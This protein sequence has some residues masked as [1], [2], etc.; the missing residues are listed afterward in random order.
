MISER[1]LLP[2]DY[3]LGPQASE[4]CQANP[5]CVELILD[6]YTT[7][8]VLNHKM[9]IS[10]AD[11]LAGYP[12]VEIVNPATNPIPASTGATHT[13]LTGA[14]ALVGVTVSSS[15]ANQLILAFS[16]PSAAPAG[17]TIQILLTRNPATQ[18]GYP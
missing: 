10:A 9:H 12:L 11:L 17:T 15:L 14:Q 8:Y 3:N 6:G 2:S 4:S 16:T 7:L 18:V 5:L 1:W 13:T